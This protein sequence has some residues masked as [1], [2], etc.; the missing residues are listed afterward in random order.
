LREIV[1]CFP[2]YRTCIDAA[3]QPAEA[4]RRDLDWALAQARRNEPDLDPSV[5]D[6]LS[7]LLSGDLVAKPQRLQPQRRPALRHEAAAI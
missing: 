1:A 4:D 5:F 2:V 3:G 6:F 7:K